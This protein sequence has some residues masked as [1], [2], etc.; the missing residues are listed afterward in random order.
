LREVAA[1]HLPSAIA[2]KRKQGF[3][4]PLDTWVDARFKAQVR[5]ALMTTP[6]SLPDFM[7]PHYY[8]PW[9]NAFAEG[10]QIP[11]IS[12]ESLYQRVL[13]LLSLW[14]ML[15]GHQETV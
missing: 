14:L 4:I 9:L 11:G 8:G 7:D 1:R 5:H 10:T 12:R 6:G 15:N 2:T 13:M 3:S